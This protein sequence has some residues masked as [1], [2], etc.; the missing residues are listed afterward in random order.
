VTP[1]AANLHLF[2]GFYNCGWFG[3]AIPA[4]AVTFGCEFIQSNYSWRIPLILQASSCVFVMLFV[5]LIPESPRYLM[6]NGRE[7]EA[8]AFL[9]KYHGNGDASSRLVR[10]EID[11]MR[12]Y[13]RIDGIDKNSW[14]C[15]PPTPSWSYAV[16]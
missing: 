2:P 14:D 1:K 15:E 13:I 8:V 16:C 10:L 7:E 12:E 6:A 9:A 3:G 4:A 5:F 11:E